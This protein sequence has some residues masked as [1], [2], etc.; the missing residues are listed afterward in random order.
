MI[1]G[2]GIHRRQAMPEGDDLL[3]FAA[4]RAWDSSQDGPA[5]RQERPR[6]SHVADT[7][8]R[9]SGLKP[10]LWQRLAHVSART[11]FSFQISFGEKLPVCG[12]DR[13]AGYAQ[14]IGKR[15]C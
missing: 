11:Q 13:V 4:Y 5:L 1:K 2:K 10:L 7:V 8:P 15:S 14:F 6:P 12:H 3:L 9:R